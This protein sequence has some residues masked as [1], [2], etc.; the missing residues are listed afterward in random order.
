MSRNLLD[1]GA[2]YQND[3]KKVILKIGVN[4]AT[5][6]INRDLEIYSTDELINAF[7]YKYRFFNAEEN[8]VQEAAIYSPYNN[9]AMKG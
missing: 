5:E 9:F 4:G 2:A 3:I 6:V 8:R 7:S 1:K